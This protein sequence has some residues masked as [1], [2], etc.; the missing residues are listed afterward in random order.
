MLANNKGNKIYVINRKFYLVFNIVAL[1]MF[2]STILLYVFYL[3]DVFYMSNST[4]EVITLALSFMMVSLLVFMPYR[5][6]SKSNLRY[7]SRIPM[8]MYVYRVVGVLI[9]LIADF[10]LFVLLNMIDTCHGSGGMT[11]SCV[12]RTDHN[13]ILALIASPALL[14]LTIEIAD[15]VYCF[16]RNK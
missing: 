4:S 6:L 3:F 11:L 12:L 2:I 8:S 13:I 16:N 7:I 1:I 5:F 10:A 15:R 9:A 14:L